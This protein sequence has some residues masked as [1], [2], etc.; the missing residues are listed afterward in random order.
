MQGA[1]LKTVGLNQGVQDEL[2]VD[3]SGVGDFDV[4]VEVDVLSSVPMAHEIQ[5]KR[6]GPKRKRGPK[7][8]KAPMS[9][10]QEK[11]NTLAVALAAGATPETAL[12]IAGYSQN[13]NRALQHPDVKGAVAEMRERLQ[14]TDGFRLEDSA[15]FYKELSEDAENHTADRIKA[16]SRMDSLLGYDAPQKLEVNEKRELRQAVLVLSNLSNMG[17]TPAE[18]ASMLQSS[19]ASDCTQMSREAGASFEAAED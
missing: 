6:R 19:S 4:G 7:P 10:T 1:K 11:H 18:L 8:V 15:G 16:R 5:R 3:V 17:I 12:S 13:S 14:S 9:K 2:C